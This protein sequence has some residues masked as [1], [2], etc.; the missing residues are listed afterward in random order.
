[1]NGYRAL[2]GHLFASVVDFYS[3]EPATLAFFRDP[4]ARVV[5]EYRFIRR[6]PAH[7]RH[8]LVSR[9]TLLEFVSAPGNLAVYARFLGY[10][11][12]AGDYTRMVAGP[13]VEEV[14]GRSKA[15]IDRLAFVGLTE[16]FSED[17]RRLERWLGVASSHVPRENAAPDEAGA[18]DPAVGEVVRTL[19]WAEYEI[20][21][22][23]VRAHELA[24]E[25][26]A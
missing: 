14:V 18:P 17:Y 12:D 4:L 25:A 3:V 21:D 5:S 1:L 11:P 13:S 24:A 7:G 8:E 10:R 19:G 22:H 20:Y 2:R 26:S 6:T 15:V 9:Q 23:A 16:A